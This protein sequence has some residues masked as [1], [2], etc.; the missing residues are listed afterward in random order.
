MNVFA[1]S[2]RIYRTKSIFCQKR[3]GRSRCEDAV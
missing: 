2:L 1:A 3:K